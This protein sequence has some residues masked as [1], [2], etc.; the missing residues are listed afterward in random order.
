MSGKRV[1]QQVTIVG[2]VDPVDEKNKDAGIKITTADEGEFVVELS[3]EGQRLKH[4]IGEQARVSGIVT[5][6][7]GGKNLISVSKFKILEYEEELGDY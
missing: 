4:M 3:K 1:N 6:V 7:K 5:T 2:Y